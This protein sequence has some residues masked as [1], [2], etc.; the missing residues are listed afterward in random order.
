MYGF[1]FTP[2]ISFIYDVV[3]INYQSFLIWLTYNLIIQFV[4]NIEW[5]NDA[6]R[7][8]R[9]ISKVVLHMCMANMPNEIHTSSYWHVYVRWSTVSMQWIAVNYGND[10]IPMY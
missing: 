7:S 6:V 9:L 4:S 2:I 8:R 5:Q 1:P 3:I 10:L